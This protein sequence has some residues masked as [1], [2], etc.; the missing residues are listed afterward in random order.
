M[1]V[2]LEWGWGLPSS[3][4][5]RTQFPCMIAL[6]EPDGGKPH[7][8]YM[9]PSIDTHEDFVLSANRST[10]PERRYVPVRPSRRVYPWVQP[11]DQWRIAYTPRCRACARARH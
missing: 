6:H 4:S 11:W 2:S 8:Y 10:E 5:P 1:K 9:K 3:G 7:P